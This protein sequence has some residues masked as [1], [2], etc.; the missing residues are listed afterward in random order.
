MSFLR[1]G[2]FAIALCLLPLIP[3]WYYEYLPLQDYANHLARLTIME[4]YGHS[5][6]YRQNFNFDYF[7]GISPLPYLALDI[8][9]AKIMPFF[10]VDKAMRIF[11]S[12]YV[13]LCLVSVYLLARRSKQE[14][15]LLLLILLPVI[16]SSYFH[17]GFMNFIFSV[18]LL[19]LLLWVV[20]RYEADRNRFD[21][22]LIGIFS[23]LV[24]LSHIVTLFIF[25]FFMLCHLFTRRLRM[26]EYVYILAALAPSLILSVN[27]LILTTNNNPLGVLKYES[28]RDPISS[29][30][31][32]LTT[33]FSYLPFSFIL[34]SSMVYAI[35][36]LVI[37][38]TS[39]IRDRLYLTFAIFLLI[40]YFALPLKGVEGYYMDI[41]YLDVRFLFFFLML[42]PFSL[43]FKQHRDLDF[44]RLLLCGIAFIC[45]Y[46]ILFSFSDFN[47]TFSASC[48]RLMAP[49]SSLYPINLVEA[50][51]GMRPYNSAWGYF[52]KDRE[53]LT[54]FIFTG[55]HIS[56]SYRKRPP[57]LAGASLTGEDEEMNQ[58]SLKTLSQSYDYVILT[59]G[60][61]KVR[62]SLETVSEEV[63]SEKLVHV[64]KI[65]HN[66]EH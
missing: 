26:K 10:D 47:R 38:K 59:G 34:A 36:L 7:K 5:E 29:K 1:S 20:E 64:Y 18:P 12:L 14:F 60:D 53:F 44:A 21:L 16:Y 17:V 43:Q 55:G 3:L 11:L 25:F 8:L 27:F 9:V 22:I 63:C 42:F 37:L 33:P 32:L 2:T 40:I 4:N 48:A 28:L 46:G 6:F 15:N 54:P 30:L 52:Y 50:K 13:I 62:H 19:M 51:S 23:L 57:I 65:E 45:F 61:P 39:A 66:G 49:K 24:Y 56:I 31:I 41:Y 35:A 58:Q